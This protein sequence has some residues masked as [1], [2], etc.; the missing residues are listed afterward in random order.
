[1]FM[2]DSGVLT[3]CLTSSGSAL[4]SA[5]GASCARASG[6]A[7]RQTGRGKL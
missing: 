1:V 4:V 3:V 6:T 7:V 5:C 2:R